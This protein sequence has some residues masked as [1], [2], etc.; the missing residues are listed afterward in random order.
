M[1]IKDAFEMFVKIFHRDGTQFVKD[2]SHLD[3]SIGVGVASVPGGH[4]Q[5]ISLLAERVQVGG[6]VMAVPQHEVDVDGNFAKPS[7]S[8]QA[9]GDIGGSQHRCNGKPDCRDH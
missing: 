9:H 3:P 6:V 4:E 2:T 5:P 7:G 8:R 1:P